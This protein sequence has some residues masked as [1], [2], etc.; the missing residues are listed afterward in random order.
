VSPKAH[1]GQ[2][3]QSRHRDNSNKRAGAPEPTRLT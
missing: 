2:S 3:D 1:S